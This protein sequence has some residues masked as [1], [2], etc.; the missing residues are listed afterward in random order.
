MAPAKLH[1]IPNGVDPDEWQEPCAPLSEPLAALVTRLRAEGQAI[2][3]YTGSHGAANALDNL[4]DAATRLRSLP[5]AFVLV[6]DGPEKRRLQ[7]RAAREGLG[8]MHFAAPIPK[9]EIPALMSRIDIAYLGWQRQPLYRFGISPNK[10]LDYMM[11]G[12]AVLHAVEA[13]NDPVLDA[14][15]GLTVPPEDPAAIADGVKR[16]FAMGADARRAL[17]ARG[18]Q[19]ALS[20]LTYPVLGQRF[21]SVLSQE[22][23]HG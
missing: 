5:V 14:G 3:G 11:G 9:R 4:L 15:C 17:G 10:L 13:G 21:L 22:M 7:Q 19:Y 12:C 1:H 23:T 18:R 8:K 6:G 16:L 2:V 20:H